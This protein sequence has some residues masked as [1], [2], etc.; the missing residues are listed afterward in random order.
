MVWLLR[1]CSVCLCWR[2]RCHRM[3]L[4]P[5][6]PN[7]P[8]SFGG[9]AHNTGAC[10]RASCRMGLGVFSSWNRKLRGMYIPTFLVLMAALGIGQCSCVDSEFMHVRARWEQNVAARVGEL[11][12]TG[13]FPRNGAR[14]G[15]PS[16]QEHR[17]V[18]RRSSDFE[19]TDVGVYGSQ[20][21]AQRA[22]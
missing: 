14:N 21:P 11:F 10:P 15:A 3:G 8:P 5:L 13:T 4:I 1:V 22:C 12:R 6:M 2:V 16:R 17:F 9:R 18:T 7:A 19:G 20:G